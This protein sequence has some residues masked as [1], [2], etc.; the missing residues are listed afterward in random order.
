M[1]HDDVSEPLPFG[2][3][4]EAFRRLTEGD[5]DEV[6][7]VPAALALSEILQGGCTWS[8]AETSLRR[9]EDAARRGASRQRSDPAAAA[10]AVMALMAREGFIGDDESYEDP[11]NSFLDRVLERRRGLPI[12]L[13]VLAVHL[14]RHAGVPLRG[15]GFPGHFLVGMRL[16]DPLPIV[17]DPFR[18]GRRLDGPALDELLDRATGRRNASTEERWREHLR[19]ASGREVIVRMLRNLMMH[20]H[21]AGRPEHAEAAQRL[22]QL[23]ATPEG[24]AGRRVR[25]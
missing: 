13:S 20:L 12:T 25:D 10:R 22:L 23:A 18:G 4:W 8:G 24:R 5:E 3:W 7:V 2:P 19:P 21:N 11:A 16:R 1:A 9:L 15:I 17:L 14:G 6:P